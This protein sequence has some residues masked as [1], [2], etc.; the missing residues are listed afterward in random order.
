[1]IMGKVCDLDV[2]H[3]LEEEN[4]GMVVDL[5]APTGSSP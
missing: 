2:A 1:M 4:V 5:V 3:H